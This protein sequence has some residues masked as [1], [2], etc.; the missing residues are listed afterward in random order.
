[1]TEWM[2]QFPVIRATSDGERGVL[3]GVIL[4]PGGRGDL[5]LKVVPSI[6]IH[7]TVGLA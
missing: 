5:K 2:F 3:D 1:M 6:D 4:D 7:I